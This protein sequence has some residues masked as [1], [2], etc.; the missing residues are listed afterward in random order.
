MGNFL[1]FYPFSENPKNQNFENN[2]NNCWRYH[3][4][5]HVYQKPQ[6]YEVQFPRYRV[7]QTKKFI[8]LGH[9]LPF[10]PPN[11]L[12]NQN[13]EKNEKSIILHKCT[14]NY[15]HMLY[16]SWDMECNRH[17]FLL[18][19]IIFCPFIALYWPWKKIVKKPRRYYPFTHVYHKWKSYDAWFL[20][21]KGTRD[22]VFSYL[23]PF[24]AL[25]PP[26]NPK[27][28]IFEKMENTPGDIIILH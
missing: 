19:W 1:P 2:E 14:K 23:G 28:Q 12:K 22:R 6:L 11:N 13:F 3:H 9:F 10:Y 18:F 27:N 4:F 16:A 15:D 20:R 21:Y 24:F 17:N 8:I 26:N 7:S 25:W 5:T